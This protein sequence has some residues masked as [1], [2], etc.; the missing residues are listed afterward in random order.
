MALKIFKESS[1]QNTLQEKLVENRL[2]GHIK[3]VKIMTRTEPVTR[4]CSVKKV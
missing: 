3:S 2:K 1:I 4:R